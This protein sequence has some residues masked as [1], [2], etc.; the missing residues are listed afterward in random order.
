[1]PNGIKIASAIF[2]KT[3]EQVRGGDMKNMVCY[4]DNIYTWAINE[5]E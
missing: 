2:E 5:K 1:M 4:K 3:I